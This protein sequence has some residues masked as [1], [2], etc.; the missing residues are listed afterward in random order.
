MLRVDVVTISFSELC[1]DRSCGTIGVGIP[2]R[3]STVAQD[4]K[5]SAFL[6]FAGLYVA[7][8]TSYRKPKLRKGEAVYR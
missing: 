2:G 1:V 4:I 6:T 8:R 3:R 5:P 7:L